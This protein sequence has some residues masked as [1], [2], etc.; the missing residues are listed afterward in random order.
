MSRPTSPPPPK[1]RPAPTPNPAKPYRG[2]A[3]TALTRAEKERLREARSRAGHI[4]YGMQTIADTW[5]YIARARAEGDHITLGYESWDAYVDGEFGEERVKLPPGKRAA[6]IAALAAVGLT[7]RETAHALGVSQPTVQRALAASR[8]SNESSVEDE[9]ADQD[10]VDAVKQAI[11][12]ATERAE[13]AATAGRVGPAV[14]SPERAAAPGPADKVGATG[15][16]PA[17]APVAEPP[18]LVD[19][20]VGP[21]TP[22]V[23][24]ALDKHVPDPNPHAEWRLGYLKRVHSVHAVMRSKPEDVARFADALCLEEL[25]ACVQELTDYH[26]AVTRAVMA[27]TPDNV[28]PIRRTS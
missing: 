21:I 13:E 18:K 8:D 17:P 19:T 16:E 3:A 20:P 22:A 25:A 15:A 2:G 5:V 27:S 28:T 26:R 1:P 24:A 4:R 11:D 9:G 23:A 6:A 14:A 7:Q 12:D 10:V